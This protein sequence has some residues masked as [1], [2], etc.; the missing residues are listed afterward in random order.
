MTRALLERCL[1]RGQ[2]HSFPV[3]HGDGDPQGQQQGALPDLS[4]P[5]PLP[6]LSSESG[7]LV[8]MRPPSVLVHPS[9]RI[10]GSLCHLLPNTQQPDSPDCEISVSLFVFQG[11]KNP[12]EDAAMNSFPS[13]VGRCLSILRLPLRGHQ[14][15]CPLTPAPNRY[16]GASRRLPE[17]H[18][19]LTIVCDNFCVHLRFFILLQKTENQWYKRNSIF[20]TKML[21]VDIC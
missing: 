3:C 5:R 16:S 11:N 14:K 2:C 8:P 13:R 7:A 12:E 21:Q 9:Y 17:G 18:R 1:A 15:S 4:S 6:Q 20:A 19:S 10:P